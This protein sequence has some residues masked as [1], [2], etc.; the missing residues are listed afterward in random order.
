MPN[1]FTCPTFKAAKQAELAGASW[2]GTTYGEND[3]LIRGY[4]NPA[5]WLH[6]PR[7]KVSKLKNI[8]RTFMVQEN[9]GHGHTFMDAT[10]GTLTSPNFPHQNQSNIV[11]VDGHTESRKPLEVPCKYGYPSISFAC[12]NNT[13]FVRS[14]PTNPGSSTYTI[15]GL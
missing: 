4:N 11:F 6:T 7:R 13:Y 9:Y 2:V 3:F 10:V 12:K 14:T 5:S 15:V 1:L 8:S